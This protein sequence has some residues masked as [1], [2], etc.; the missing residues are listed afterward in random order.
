VILGRESRS[1]AVRTRA[2]APKVVGGRT[3]EVVDGKARYEAERDPL[4]DRRSQGKL[5]Q[6]GISVSKGRV[7]QLNRSVKADPLLQAVA[8]I[9][10]AYLQR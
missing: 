3:G 9:G 6:K 8:C 4:T 1:H 10:S 7:L 5:A 2:V